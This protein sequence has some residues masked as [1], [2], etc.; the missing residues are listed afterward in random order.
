M[1]DYDAN[2]CS[3]SPVRMQGKGKGRVSLTCLQVQEGKQGW[4]HVI[5]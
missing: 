3:T 4:R 1:L 2:G 5:D